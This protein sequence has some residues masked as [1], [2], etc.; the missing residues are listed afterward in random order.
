MQ[1]LVAPQEFIF[2]PFMSHQIGL[3]VLMFVCSSLHALRPPPRATVNAA[4]PWKVKKV[5]LGYIIV[6]P[7]A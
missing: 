5:K 3:N 7:K 2:G 1:C 4:R 6:R